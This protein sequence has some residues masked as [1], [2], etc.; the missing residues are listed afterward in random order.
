MRK[1][2]AALAL[3]LILPLSACGAVPV[4]DQRP[5][6]SQRLGDIAYVPLDDRPDNWERV[7]Y[8]AASLG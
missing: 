1:Q 4:E 2:L 7:E 8:L 6:P 5:E 3:A